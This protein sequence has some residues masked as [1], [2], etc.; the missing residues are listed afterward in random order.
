[1]GT[2]RVLSLFLK[3]RDLQFCGSRGLEPQK[4]SSSHPKLEGES[5]TQVSYSGAAP[6]VYCYSCSFHLSQ[7]QA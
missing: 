4:E 7:T 3:R 1:M 5:K 6:R 2:S